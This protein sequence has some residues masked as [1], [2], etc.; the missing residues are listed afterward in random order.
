MAAKTA[1]TYFEILQDTL[2]GYLI[3]P[4]HRRTG[5]QSISAAPKFYLFDVGVAGQLCGR[6]LTEPAGPEFGRAFKHFVLQE[7]VAARGYQEK[8]FPI[9]FW[10]TKTGLEVAFVLNRGEV[11]VEVK[12][13]V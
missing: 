6:R 12:G 4:F 9:Q 7:I 10:R 1:R 5:R 8:D 2:L 3:Q 11:A 13:R